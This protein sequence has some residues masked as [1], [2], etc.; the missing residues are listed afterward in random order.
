M[1]I[2]YFLIILISPLLISADEVNDPFEEINRKT[3][4][5]NESLDKNIL[6]PVAEVYS[7]FPPKVKKGVTNFFNNLE[8][9]DTFINQ[10]LQ[11]KP[12]ESINDLSR[13]VINTTIGIGGIFDVA[14]KMGLERHEEDFG[15]TLAV[16]GVSEGPYIM[17]PFLGPSTLRDTLSRPVSSFLS[18]TFHMTEDDVN[19]A[20]KSID[21]LET[22][23]RLL[24]VE[25]LLSGD[26]YVFVKDAYIQSM[27]YEIKDGI[28]VKDEFVDD[29]DDFLIDQ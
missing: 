10:L 14:S 28:D 19:I 29:M 27:Y 7:N 17:L 9:V 21:A 25:S 13:F 16:W 18:V 26:K 3:Y 2:L 6:K 20:L 4:E 1:R 5:F 8:E 24:D 12:K 11:G 15:Q 23:E 22:R